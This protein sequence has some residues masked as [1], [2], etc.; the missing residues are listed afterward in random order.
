[1]SSPTCSECGAIST[2]QDAGLPGFVCAGCK[3]E[4]RRA[5]AAFEDDTGRWVRVP[6]G[7][8]MDEARVA[9]WEAR[10]TEKEVEDG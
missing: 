3:K 5:A 10:P 9:V 6:D 8:S 1:M 7:V 2:H 4:R